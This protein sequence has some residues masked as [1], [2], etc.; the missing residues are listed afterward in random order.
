MYE[1]GIEILGDVTLTAKYD[2]GLVFAKSEKA[3]ELYCSR[4]NAETVISS[5]TSAVAEDNKA[6]F[7]FCG[8]KYGV[9]VK[10]GTLNPDFSVNNADGKIV[11]E[12]L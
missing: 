7:E 1:K 4:N 10:T 5:I 6:T 2:E 3:T 9:T 12:V 8:V 11:I